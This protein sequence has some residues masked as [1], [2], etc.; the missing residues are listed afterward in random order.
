MYP[1]F[2]LCKLGFMGEKGHRGKGEPFYKSFALP[3][4]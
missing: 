4:L 3:R 1:L 2:Y